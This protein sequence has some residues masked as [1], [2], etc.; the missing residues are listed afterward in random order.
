LEQS[1]ED[2]RQ[3]MLARK[4]KSVYVKVNKHDNS[5]VLHKWLKDTWW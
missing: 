5:K 2:R 3:H 4:F 1:S